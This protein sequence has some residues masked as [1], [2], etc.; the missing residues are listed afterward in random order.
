MSFCVDI[1]VKVW[2]MS[3]FLEREEPIY[4][5]NREQQLG[6]GLEVISH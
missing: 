6:S 5:Y 1:N 4:G 2:C 3:D